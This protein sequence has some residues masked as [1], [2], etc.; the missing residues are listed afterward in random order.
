MDTWVSGTLPSWP[1]QS[2]PQ[3]RFLPFYEECCC[4]ISKPHTANTTLPQGQPKRTS[5]KDEL[6]WR[7]L[8]GDYQ[9]STVEPRWPQCAEHISRKHGSPGRG[10]HKSKSTLISAICSTLKARL[11]PLGKVRIVLQ[12]LK[13]LLLFS[14]FASQFLR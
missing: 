10:L 7:R 3:A 2:I 9:N 14:L 13:I 11:R 4:Q 8:P 1:G 12:A 5:I 6:C